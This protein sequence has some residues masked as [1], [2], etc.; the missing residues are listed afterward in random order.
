MP[1]R[2][3]ANDAR[4]MMSE[5]ATSSTSGEAL[6]STTQPELTSAAAAEA[7]DVEATAAVVDEAAA[8]Q[9]GM[10]TVFKQAASPKTGSGQKAAA[11]Q[12]ASVTHAKSTCHVL[13][14]RSA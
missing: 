10:T 4:G 5:V 12:E 1:A 6:N 11:R 2:W 7:A 13:S 3:P 8:G 9:R 14:Q